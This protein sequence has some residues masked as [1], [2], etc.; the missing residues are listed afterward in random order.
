MQGVW[1][2][3]FKRRGNNIGADQGAGDSAHFGE[4]LS[5]AGREEQLVSFT[6]VVALRMTMGDEFGQGAP[7]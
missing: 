3:K 4:A 1:P 2:K 5:A 7:E 6:L